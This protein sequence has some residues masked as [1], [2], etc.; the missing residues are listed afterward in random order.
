MGMT[1]A[2][3]G[4]NSYFAST[5]LPL[6]EQDETVDSIIGIDVSPW[7]GGCKKV[8]F[9][10]LDIRSEKIGELL[11]GVD[12]LYHLAFIVGEIHDKKKTHDININGSKNIFK[13]CAAKGVRKVVYTSSMTVYGSH[14]DNPIGFT[15]TAEIR[16]N[17]DSYYN[18]S[19]IAVERFVADFFQGHPQI[20]LTILRAG[21]LCGPRINNMFSELWSRRF[22]ALPMGRNSHNQLIHEEDMGTALHL[23]FKKDI[24]GI[25]NVCADDALATRWMFKAGGALS[26][27]LPAGLLKVALN[28]LFI[29]RLEKVSQ[30]WVSLCEYTIYGICEKFKAHGWKPRYTSKEAYEQFLEARKRDAK[31]S[32]KQKFLTWLYSTPRMTA[33]SLNGLNAAFY[34]IEKSSWLRDR[35]PMTDPRKNNMTYLPVNRNIENRI[36]RVIELNETVGETG[37]EIITRQV[38]DQ[39]IDESEVRLIMDRCICRTGFHCENFTNEIGCLFMG[40][41]AK[42]LP[43]GLGRLATKEEAHRH[44]DKAVEVGLVPMTERSM[45]TT[46]GF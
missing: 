8:R 9:H 35:I 21:L 41:T 34:L 38:L 40:E 27:F 22:M 43:P 15:E 18:A 46:W 5:I 19:K 20:T 4:V 42:K 1:V 39:V 32:L 25:H 17:V 3:T 11:Q 31:D 6:L 23:A 37:S 2:I 7:K 29:L 33:L 45:W 44:V 13:A 24:P 26:V 30:G 36:P 14:A 16:E 10:R 12:V 28:L